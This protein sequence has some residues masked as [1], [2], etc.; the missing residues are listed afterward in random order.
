[1]VTTGVDAA[2]QIIGLTGAD[3]TKG[4]AVRGVDGDIPNEEMVGLMD[5]VDT[6]TEAMAAM[7]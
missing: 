6:P 5:R 7:T 1:M 2:T 4:D 3:V